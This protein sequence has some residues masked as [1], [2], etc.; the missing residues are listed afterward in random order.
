MIRL[1]DSEFAPPGELVDSS[2]HE[3]AA[4]AVVHRFTV[5]EGFVLVTIWRDVVHE[6]IYQTPCE[7]EEDSKARDR[8]LFAHHGEGHEWREILD[9]GFGKTYR[10]ADL[11]RFALW[12]YAMDF[13]TF[14]TMAF[15]EVMWG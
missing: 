14:G 5:P 13:T 12:S 15:H 2:P 10:R 1:L 8:R 3:H 11:E 4:G 9:N 7:F 6:V